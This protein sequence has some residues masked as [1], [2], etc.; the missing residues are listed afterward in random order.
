MEPVQQSIALAMAEG[1]RIVGQLQQVR[2]G[3]AESSALGAR[4]EE[5]AASYRVRIDRLDFVQQGMK[6][7][8]LTIRLDYANLWKLLIDKQ[9]NK[10]DLKRE[11]GVSVASIACLNKG[12]NVTTDTLL[13]ICQYLD[14]GLPEICEIV[15]VDSPNES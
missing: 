10:E 12:D 14:C 4:Y 2:E 15:L 3:L 11:A 8:V 6:T 9:R 5:L 13:R 1:Q 7:S